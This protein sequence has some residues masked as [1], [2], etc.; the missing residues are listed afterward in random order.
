[1]PDIGC[2]YDK[3]KH[4]KLNTMN[5]PVG[6]YCQCVVIFSDLLNPNLHIFKPIGVSLLGQLKPMEGN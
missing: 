5:L 3:E 4:T 2:P 6:R 1:M